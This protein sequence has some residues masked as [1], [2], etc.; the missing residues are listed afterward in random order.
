MGGHIL[1][2]LVERFHCEPKLRELDIL[3]GYFNT[4]KVSNIN[5]YNVQH[6]VN[7]YHYNMVYIKP[8]VLV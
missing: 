7:V 6:Y 3:Q 4:G 2:I 8:I 1:D 5:K